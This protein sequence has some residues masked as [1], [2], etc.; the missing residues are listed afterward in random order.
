[1]GDNS[2]LYLQFLLNPSNHRKRK[3]KRY[4]ASCAAYTCISPLR[5][6]LTLLRIDFSDPFWEGQLKPQRTGLN[7]FSPL[8]PATNPA[9]AL[10]NVDMMVKCFKEGHLGEYQGYFEHQNAVCKYLVFNGTIGDDST[11][12]EPPQP[13]RNSSG[14]GPRLCVLTTDGVFVSWLWH[15]CCDPRVCFAGVFRGVSYISLFRGH[16]YSMLSV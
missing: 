1:M 10:D 3:L 6:E 2:S 16:R 4:G 14:I 15:R 5:D 11:Q 7:C 13:A 9:D 8:G 12:E